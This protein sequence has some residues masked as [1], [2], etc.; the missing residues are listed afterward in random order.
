[1]K[2]K[3]IKY[4]RRLLKEAC[5]E[6][7][8]WPK[9][10]QKNAGLVFESEQPSTKKKDFSMKFKHISKPKPFGVE[11][12]VGDRVSFEACHIEG[13]VVFELDASTRCSDN[14]SITPDRAR[15]MGLALIKAAEYLEQKGFDSK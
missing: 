4:E 14:L 8:S 12:E 3:D 7:R 9:W 2:K 6:V 10:R 11:N 13:V 15:K 1:M 5:T